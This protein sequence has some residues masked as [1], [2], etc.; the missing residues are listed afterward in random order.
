MKSDEVAKDKDAH[1]KHFLHEA[2]HAIAL[3]SLAVPPLCVSVEILEDP[4]ATHGTV[5]PS[6]NAEISLPEFAFF[7]MCGPA[8]HLFLAGC[9]FDTEVNM[10]RSD[11]TSVLKQFPSLRF[12]DAQ[13]GRTLVACRTLMEKYCRRWAEDHRE[14]IL[15]LGEALQL[16]NVRQ[17]YYELKES[18]LGAALV[19]AGSGIQSNAAEL[20]A[21]IR[22]AFEASWRSAAVFSPEPWLE[23]YLGCVR[24]GE[25]GLL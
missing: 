11:F 15:K 2:G 9:Q 16:A 1:R 17:R 24:A 19:A 18:T 4:R 8:S 25:Q 6:P 13:I 10:F 22:S 14:P 21:A 3:Y 12:S 23:Y 7:K 5:T 20:R